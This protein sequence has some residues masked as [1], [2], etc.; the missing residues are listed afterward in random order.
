MPFYLSILPDTLLIKTYTS[1]YHRNKT[2]K[3][4]TFNYYPVHVQM[5]QGSEKHLFTFDLSQVGSRVV[6]F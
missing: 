2:N 6:G 5:T 1:I 3:I 4:V